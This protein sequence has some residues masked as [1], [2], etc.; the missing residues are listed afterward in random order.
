MTLGLCDFTP[1][2]KPN[3]YYVP[4]NYKQINND[5]ADGDIIYDMYR[6][7]IKLASLAETAK[8]IA[9]VIYCI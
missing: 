5:K 1:T 9:F 7:Y 6:Q 8:R 2:L 4:A 3:I